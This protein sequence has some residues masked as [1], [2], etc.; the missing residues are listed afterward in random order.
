[1]SS[2][3]K[4][5][6]TGLALSLAEKAKGAFLAFAAGD[7]LGWPQEIPRNVR[8]G[9]A[10]HAPGEEFREWTRRSGGRFLPYEE[11]V[12]AGEYSDDT[13][14]ALAVARSRINHGSNWW[15]VFTL[16]ELPFWS[17]YERGGG[18]ATKRAVVAWSGG[19]PPWRLEN[20]R[21][22]RGYFDA[23]GNGVA[24]RVLPHALFFANCENSF[25][26]VRDVVFD[27]LATHGHPRALV[28]ATAYAYAAWRLLRRSATLRF[29][30]LLDML[31]DEKREWAGFPETVKE[32]ST[33]FRAVNAASDGRY[34]EIWGQTVQEMTELLQTARQEV[35]AGALAD[36]SSALEKLGCLGREKGSG[37]RSTAAAAYLTSRHAAL[38][39]QG[40]I[41]AAFEKGADTDTLAAMT[42]GLMGCLAGAEWIPRSWL[43]V[44]DAEYIQRVADH[45]ISGAWDEPH[46]HVEFFPYRRSVLSVLEGLNGVK[47][48]MVDLGDGKKAAVTVLS[49]MK[50]IGK[51][52][53][54]KGWRFRTP[55][56]QTLY[57]RK[58]SKAS[59]KSSSGSDYSRGASVRSA[60]GRSAPL[61]R[62]IRPRRR[63]DRYPLLEEMGGKPQGTVNKEPAATGGEVVESASPESL[64]LYRL[65]CKQLSLF[66][67]K[68][69][70]Q[71]KLLDVQNR[72]G[73][74]RTQVQVWL[75]RAEQ[76]GLIRKTKKRPVTY[77]LCQA[78]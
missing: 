41:R 24:M 3:G 35:L 40:V 18:G 30:E 67:G 29:G 56:G 5:E 52:V 50:P 11:F 14:L 34:D 57:M 43:K 59:A 28:G 74:E 42:G 2:N 23:G 4:N 69:S 61:S 55:E 6:A 39:R 76:D 22:V 75:D 62:G 8:G 51:S 38:P 72:L 15:K 31:I 17:L 46:A 10:D 66:F 71:I 12:R 58:V 26:L 13:Q 47:E 77:E 73:L 19:N 64:K 45:L 1:M 63:P 70:G 44:Q 20:G 37:I 27:G 25:D 33:W 36:D 65:F 78:Q 21:S 54:V 53:M 16:E 32:E 7:A 68:S 48:N 9:I 49:D 60:A